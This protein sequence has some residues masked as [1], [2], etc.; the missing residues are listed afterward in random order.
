MVYTVTP[1]AG[2]W[3]EISNS[4]YEGDW[5]MVTPFAGVWIEILM[6]QI[7]L[8]PECVTPFAGVWIEIP[9]RV[10]RDQVGKCHSLRGS[11]D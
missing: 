3:I 6:R 1:F 8:S 7:L 9:S 5:E 2:V 10:M 4:G 11:V